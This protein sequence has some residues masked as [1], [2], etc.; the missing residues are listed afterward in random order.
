MYK[1]EHSNVQIRHSLLF[2][3]LFI[4]KA[5]QNELSNLNFLLHVGS[6]NGS[7]TEALPWILRVITSDFEKMPQ[8]SESTDIEIQKREVVIQS[9]GLGCYPILR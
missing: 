9:V 1:N 2:Q 3:F 8:M 6:F 5:K 4:F 7:S